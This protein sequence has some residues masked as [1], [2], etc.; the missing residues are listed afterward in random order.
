MLKVYQNRKHGYLYCMSRGKYRYRQEDVGTPKLFSVKQDI[1]QHTPS[2]K[3]TA[4][5][6]AWSNKNQYYKPLTPNLI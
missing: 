3:G 6:H 4:Q 2:F 1:I 5:C